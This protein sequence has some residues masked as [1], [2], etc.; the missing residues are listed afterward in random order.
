MDSKL[1]GMCSLFESLKDT[2]NIV[3]DLTK[4]DLCAWSS[5][6]SQL[7]HQFKCTKGFPFEEALLNIDYNEKQTNSSP[8]YVSTKNMSV[9]FQMQDES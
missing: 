1:I 7:V 5:I 6:V 8:Y 3:F 9:T 4:H 2:L